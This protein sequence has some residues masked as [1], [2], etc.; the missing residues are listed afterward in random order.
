MTSH[1]CGRPAKGELKNGTP[2][3]G[4]HLHLEARAAER[5]AAWKVSRERSDEMKARAQTLKDALV[6]YC[7]RSGI[8]P[9][10][11]GAP[12]YDDRKMEYTGNVIVRGDV[13]A[14]LLGVE[15]DA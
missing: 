6:D 12:D 5:E 14:R 11:V 2:A 4:V 9:E 8:S 1:K 10:R 7:E 3:C 15:Y 13:L